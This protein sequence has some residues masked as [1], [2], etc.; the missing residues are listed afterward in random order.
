MAD[1]EKLA[2]WLFNNRNALNLRAQV[3]SWV[4]DWLPG[5]E[6]IRIQIQVNG[7]FYEGR[8]ISTDQDKS[9]LIA[10]AEAI[11]RAYCD[12]LAIHSNGVALHTNEESAKLNAKLE[13]LERDGFLCHFLTKTPF[14]NFNP[15][16]DMNIDFEQIKSRLQKK[17]VEISLK[18]VIYSSPQI[19]LCIARK[20]DGSNAF[21]SI[22]G[23]G[24]HDDIKLS[25][26]KAITECL[27]NV[28][29]RLEDSSESSLSLDEF[30]NKTIHRPM[31]H[32]KVYFGNDSELSLDW[33]FDSDNSQVINEVNTNIVIEFTPLKA[34]ISI[35]EDA[36]ITVMRA[37]STQLQN[38]FYGPTILEKINVHRLNQ[39]TGA[40]VDE[41]SINWM[42]HPIG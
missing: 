31:D 41:T 11:E 22:L 1:K 27:S 16:K 29:W 24:S 25:T 9:F 37:T 2:E 36:P 7:K 26:A 13:L 21:N 6:D 42:P 15:P 5:F 8:G 20:K 17:G 4:K 40:N 14:A 30:K 32:Q 10:G 18:K 23:L 19:V 28:V 12:N 33:I 34:G 35:L 38:I 3:G 39:F